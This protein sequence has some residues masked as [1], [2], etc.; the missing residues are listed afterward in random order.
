MMNEKLLTRWVLSI[1][2]DRV[3]YLAIINKLFSI[4]Y[5]FKIVKKTLCINEIS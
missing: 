5:I 3:L 4:E 2:T 1:L